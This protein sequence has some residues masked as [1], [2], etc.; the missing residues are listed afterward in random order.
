VKGVMRKVLYDHVVDF[1]GKVRE[2]HRWTATAVERRLFGD[3]GG[4]LD[5]VMPLNTTL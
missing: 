3:V 1:G 2:R 4:S 5:R